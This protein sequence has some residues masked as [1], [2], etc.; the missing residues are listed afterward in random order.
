MRIISGKLKGR[1]ID[2][3]DILGT[4]PTMAR[5]KESLFATIQNNI[6]NTIVLD[7]FSGSGNYG[8]EAYSNGSKEVY[9]NDKNKECIKVIKKN[10]NNL[11]IN[12]YFKV[13]N[14]D[15]RECL[16]YLK[17]KNLTF[18]LVF[19]DPPYKLDVCNEILEYFTK[20]HLLNDKA[21]VICEVTNNNLKDKYANLSQVK[22][23]KYG[24]KYVL[25]Y[26]NKI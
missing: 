4:R 9:L 8:I 5:V 10:I 13:L 7:L 26:Q 21:L 23:K 22:I 3:Y 12:D 17:N 16:N 20:C 18:D 24:E 19:L 6:K 1:N 25:I 2:G 11:N 14:M 15:Y